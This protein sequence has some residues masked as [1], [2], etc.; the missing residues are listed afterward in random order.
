MSDSV[1][2]FEEMFRIVQRTDQLLWDAYSASK[3]RVFTPGS[4]RIIFPRYR[5]KS[6]Q[7]TAPGIR[8]SEQE[9]RFLFVSQLNASQFLYSVETPTSGEY[10]FKDDA[11][12]KRSAATDVTVYT[13]SAK[14]VSNVEFKAHGFSLERT[15]SLVITKDVVKLLREP[16]PAF[17]HHTLEAADNSNI[18]KL[19]SVIRRDLQLVG[20]EERERIGTKRFVFHVCVLRQRF[21][22]QTEVLIEGNH[23][24]V[25]WL[26]DFPPPDYEVTEHELVR[27]G[28]SP[29][30][31]A[32]SG[33]ITPSNP[34]SA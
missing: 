8:V 25:D 4:P 12:G 23:I 5:A 22:L 29:P 28:P 2:E 31:S 34:G 33:C 6:G 1:S 11:R 13:E 9:A 26:G 19:W 32:W 16:V 17:W 24:G 15:S 30:W 27:S 10:S 3:A 18:K 21:A 14:P 7:L 20:G